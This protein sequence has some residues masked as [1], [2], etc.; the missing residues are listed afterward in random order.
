MIG[1]RSSHAIRR[2][3]GTRTRWLLALSAIAVPALPVAAQPAT[4]DELQTAKRAGVLGRTIH[5]YDRAAWV[6][7]DVAVARLG[8][9]R[10]TGTGGWVVEPGDGGDL[11]VTFYRGEP[12]RAVAT[13]VVVV[14]DGKPVSEQVPPDGTALTER[15]RQLASARQAAVAE[16][17]R[18]KFAPCTAA[19]FNHVVLPSPEPAGGLHVYLLSAQVR[20]GV[21]PLGGHYRVDLGPDSRVRDAR[22]FTKSCIDLGPPASDK[23]EPAFLAVSH[24]L[25]PTPTEIHVFT[26]YTARLPVLVITGEHRFWQVRGDEITPVSMKR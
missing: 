3:V 10:M 5:A 7:S 6:A 1:R 26:S 22:R 23:G 4:V 11:A 17:V 24:L 20:T 9:D 13:F 18:R 14:R 25:D 15:Q 19:P 8:R 16:A 2:Q 12:E 21:Y